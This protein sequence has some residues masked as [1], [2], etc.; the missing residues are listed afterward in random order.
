MT[1]R[2]LNHSLFSVIQVSKAYRYVVLLND[3]WEDIVIN[4]K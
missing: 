2:T 3:F 1:Q 4:C